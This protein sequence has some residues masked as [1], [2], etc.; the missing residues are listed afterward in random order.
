MAMKKKNREKLPELPKDQKIK[1]NSIIHTA[2]VAAGGVGTGLAQIPL[3]DNA[4]ITPIQITMII[5]LGK[6]FEQ[7]VT[8]T[9]AKA[10]LTGAA[11]SIA[12]RGVSQVLF[13]WIPGLGNVINTA[14]AAGITE[15]IGWMAVDHFRRLPKD[16]SF[17][18]DEEETEETKQTQDESEPPD[19]IQILIDEA[20]EFLS[21]RKNYRDHNKEY[22]ALLNK[23][24]SMKC[25]ISKDHPRY[26]EL[27]DIQN[28]LMDLQIY[29]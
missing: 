24:D 21:K 12:G 15:A 25:K 4:L 3:A 16:A 20:Q 18:A 19:E 5:S 2:S 1:C 6:V 14:T 11:A 26:K 23:F 29:A 27:S 9:A 7:R 10:I 28:K 17:T 13:G 8:E 22:D